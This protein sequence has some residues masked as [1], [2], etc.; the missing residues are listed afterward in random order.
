MKKTQASDEIISFAV[1][2]AAKYSDNHK[3]SE[4]FLGSPQ[5]NG[6]RKMDAGIPV[7][8]AGFTIL[9]MVACLSSPAVGLIIDWFARRRQH[10]RHALN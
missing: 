8:G 2:R 6:E 7:L 4:A 10:G 5:A 9:F 1:R 3:E